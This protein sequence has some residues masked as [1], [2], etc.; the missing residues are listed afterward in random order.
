[1]RY[2]PDAARKVTGRALGHCHHPV[3]AAARAKG[4]RYHQDGDHHRR[5]HHRMGLCCG[6]GEETGGEAK[7]PG[8]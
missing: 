2:E 8:R 4:R 7:T 6:R 1:M 5:H 3:S